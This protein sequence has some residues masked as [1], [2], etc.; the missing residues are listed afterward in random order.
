[1]LGETGVGTWVMYGGIVVLITGLVLIFLRTALM[2]SLLWLSPVA[3]A[4]ARIG[5]RRRLVS[6]D[7]DEPTAAR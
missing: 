3:S 7:E 2:V 4:L 1:M 6:P 5:R